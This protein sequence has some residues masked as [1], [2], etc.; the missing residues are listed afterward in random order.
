MGRDISE[1]LEALGLGKYV[2]V[3]AENEIDCEALPHLTEDDLKEIGVALGARRKLLAAIARLEDKIGPRPDSE[4]SGD[5]LGATEAERRQL[6]VMFCDLVGSTELS[7]KLDPEDLRE[8]M[9]R[10]QDAVAGAIT[11]YEGYV[12][13]FLGDGVLAYFGWP[14]AHEDQAERAVRAGLDAVAE[15]ARLTLD[16]NVALQ[17]RVGIA[18]GQVVIG[19]IVGEA[20]TEADAVAGETPNLAAR[21]QGL[22]MPGQVMIG[23]TTRLLIGETFDFTDL[24]V[25]EL[26][27]FAEPVAAWHVVGESAAE[28]RFEAAH[29]GALT[30]LVGRE[31][32]LGLLRRAWEQ[33][34]T[35]IGQVVL[36]SGE[37]GIGK[38]WGQSS[39]RKAVLGSPSAVRPIIPTALSIRSLPTLSGFCAGS[40]KM[41]PR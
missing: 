37:P 4:I 5:R 3:F 16:N 32:E 27:G 39:R 33:G 26:K 34:R 17:A 1:W 11:R 30:Q 10:Y 40:V 25:Q 19:D 36:V 14:Q 2:E 21:L 6:T 22:A 18:T 8:V 35:G 15:V 24:G 31:H 38:S 20:A 12:A 23:A 28:S 13:K 29:P 7:H 9:R 41:M